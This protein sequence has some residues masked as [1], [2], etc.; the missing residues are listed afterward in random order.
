MSTFRQTGFRQTGFRQPNSWQSR[1]LGS[2]PQS[3][4]AHRVRLAIE[5][6]EEILLFSGSPA[7]LAASDWRQQT[8]SL[9]QLDLQA[10][11][12]SIAGG[13]VSAEANAGIAM[14]GAIQAQ[15]QFG[16]NGSGYSVAILDT[17]IDYNN[18]TFAG[19]YL[20]GWNF[21]DNN[22]DTMDY[23]GHGTHV[24][25][26][27][28]SDD[29]ILPGIAPGVG[30]ISLK[31]LD[32]SG[33]GTFGNVDAALQ[34]VAAHQQQYHI[35]A[36]NMS[37]GAGNY[38]SEPFTFLDADL[39]TLVNEGVFIAAA[40]GNSYFSYGSQPGLAFP[41]INNSVVS[42]G[43]VWDGSFGAASWANGAKDYTT[44]PDQIASFTQRSS[45][46]DILAPGAYV[47]STYLNDSYASMA[48]TS[49][50]SPMVAAAAALVHEALDQKG[51]GSAANESNILAILKATGVSIVDGAYGQ[52]NVN[53][54]WLTFKR[55]DVYSALETVLGANYSPPSQ[56][57]GNN[58]PSGHLSP[59]AAFVASLYESILGRQVD[60]T[61]LVAWVDRLNAGMSRQQLI[62]F[63]WTSAEHRAS[64]VAEDYQAFLHRA[65][66][67]GEIAQWVAAIQ[68]G[69]SEDLVTDAFLHSQEYLWS[70]ASNSAFVQKLFHDI[71]GRSADPSGLTTWTSALDRGVVSRSELADL[72]LHSNE[73][74]VD[75]IGG[76]YQQFLGRA[77]GAGEKQTWAALVD[78]GFL[79]LPTVAQALL[80]S[81]EFFDRAAGASGLALGR[82]SLEPTHDASN[83]GLATANGDLD[84]R[85]LIFDN[86][87]EQ[88]ASNAGAPAA[89]N[90]GLPAVFGRQEADS[91]PTPAGGLS[92]AIGSLPAAGSFAVRPI[93]A[94]QALADSEQTPAEGEPFAEF[95]Q[96]DFDSQDEADLALLAEI[97]ELQQQ[98]ANSAAG[99]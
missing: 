48:G 98:A 99:R 57:P 38:T 22:S 12:A 39:Q 2:S 58:A 34:W 4:P 75:E 51:E 66:S 33:T 9:D 21:V 93:Q 97:R 36:V 15:Q 82:M 8:F 6:L 1:C 28:G 79:S 86:W 76:Y 92:S 69:A 44:A 59:N 72:V 18:P 84:S 70:D 50:A 65:A 89:S 88:D 74:N 61:G 46:L 14:T 37:L 31:V 10:N 7:E 35:A 16:L 90:A 49:M 32:N 85:S 81:Q 78:E 45:A 25:G 94:R 20:G 80:G 62:D 42:V 77:A 55:L 73:R 23:N 27:I 29:P 17:G 96:D 91:S 41:A 64:E 67:S 53:H 43:A 40:S 60:P 47:T 63:L 26:I 95:S 11:S 52:D 5:Q 30:I 68:A 87:A 13:T 83:G 56:S 54:T 19:R 71:L 24:A 3:S